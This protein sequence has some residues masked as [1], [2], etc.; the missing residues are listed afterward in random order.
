MRDFYEIFKS[1]PELI[2]PAL[3]IAGFVIA[4]LA[5]TLLEIVKVINK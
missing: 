5:E 4:S 1:D 3:L 2:I